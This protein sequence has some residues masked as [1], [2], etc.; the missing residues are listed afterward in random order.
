MTCPNCTRPTPAAAAPAA[1][2]APLAPRLSSERAKFCCHECF[3][4]YTWAA[5]AVRAGVPVG[6]PSGVVKSQSTCSEVGGD[7]RVEVGEMD[8]AFAEG[9]QENAMFE[10]QMMFEGFDMGNE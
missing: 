2:S 1:S 8:L 9:E 3:W 4:T 6:R 10:Y 7:V 5:E